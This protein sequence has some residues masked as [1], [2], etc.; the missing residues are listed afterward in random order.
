MASTAELPV[1]SNVQLPAAS[2]VEFRV[3]G[4]V[5]VNRDG[6]PVPVPGQ[7]AMVILAALLLSPNLVVS[8][9]TL[10]DWRWGARLPAH[11]RAALQSGVSRLRGLLGDDL[12]ETAAYGYRLRITAGQLDLLRFDECV[13]DAERALAADAPD[14]ALAALEGAVGL[15]RGSP[16]SNV[17]SPALQ[18]EAI[19]RLTERYLRAAETRA[20]LCLRL[21]RQQALVPELWAL[22]QHH[23]FHER[24]AGQLMIALMRGGRQADALAVY[25]RLRQALALELGIDPTS[26]LQDLHAR[27]LSA[28]PGWAAVSAASPPDWLTGF[29]AA[30]LA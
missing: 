29:L 19:P 4:A 21:G 16:L 7:T 18:R 14:C 24:L 13:A 23:P 26:A 9:D 12:L 3:L 10:I 5:E 25:E 11:P 17:N 6:R 2:T 30:R 28:D 1:A 20:G 8:V 27:I 15:W 22:L